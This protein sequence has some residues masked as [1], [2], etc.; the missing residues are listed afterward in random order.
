MKPLTFNLLI[1]LLLIICFGCENEQS[2]ERRGIMTDSSSARQTNT[3]AFP[4]NSNI[5]SNSEKF[6][7]TNVTTQNNLDVTVPAIF[8]ISE[9]DIETAFAQGE[10]LSR[11][12]SGNKSPVFGTENKVEFR[13]QPQ[14]KLVLGIAFKKPFDEAQELGFN[15]AK[16]ASSDR[17]AALINAKKIIAQHSKQVNFQVV[18]KKWSGD[19]NTPNVRF[20]IM[21][22]DGDPVPPKK[23]PQL[24]FC[25]GKDILS[26]QNASPLVF[27]LFEDEK[28]V[29]TNKMESF[30]LAINVDATGNE[31]SFR[32]K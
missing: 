3:N 25:V 15:F 14:V 20:A 9:A 16:T 28:P 32:L 10:N 6:G 22:A 17:V 12:K 13:L 2:N 5:N 7:S 24:D 18:V 29:L 26:C 27:Q 1:C 19:E 21:D 11:N 23:N 30:T 8:N 4:V 31:T